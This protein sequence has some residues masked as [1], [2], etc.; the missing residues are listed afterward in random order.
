MDPVLGDLPVAILLTHYG[1]RN[2]NLKC[3]YVVTAHW[4]DVATLTTKIIL[5]TIL[6]VECETGVV[7]SVGAALFNCL[8][9]LDRD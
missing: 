4:V 5:L 8:K 9:G 7:Q 3:F 6:D 2:R 1:W